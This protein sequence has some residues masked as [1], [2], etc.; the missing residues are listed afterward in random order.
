MVA[1]HISSGSRGLVS[2]A[3]AAL[4][5]SASAAHAFEDARYQGRFAAEFYEAGQFRSIGIATFAGTDG[6]NFSKALATEMRAVQLN[7]E[8]WFTVKSGNNAAQS[9]ENVADAV[10]A[11]KATDVK[12][13]FAG[14]VTT[15]KISRTDRTEQRADPFAKLF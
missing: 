6:A 13:V 14:T 10:R 15:A 3:A 5:F 9:G 12:A 4:T 2:I 8:A 1:R 11:G 7:S